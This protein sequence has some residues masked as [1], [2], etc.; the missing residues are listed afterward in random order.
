MS[1]RL[2][3]FAILLLVS[4]AVRGAQTILAIS[5]ERI[6]VTNALAQ[7]VTGD[8]VVV[9]AGQAV[10]T[11]GIDISQLGITLKGAGYYVY[12][13]SS[14]LSNQTG[15][16]TI[17]VDEIADRQD[18]I[19]SAGWANQDPTLQ[20]R[21]S[22]FQFHRGTN[23]TSDNNVGTIR[24]IGSLNTTGLSNSN[25]RI[26]HCYF[27]KLYGRPGIYAMAGVIDNCY[28]D[29]G[30]KAGIIFDGK[31]PNSTQ[32]GH[33]SWATDVPM[34]TV[35]EGVY[36]ENCYFT[37]TQARGCTDGF[38]GSRVVFRDNTVDNAS[39]ENHGTDS[40]NVNRGG[41]WLSVYR[42]VFGSIFSQEYAIH[43]RSGSGVI[44][45]NSVSGSYPGLWRGRNY[46]TIAQ[47]APF[48]AAN[49]TNVW[50]DNDPNIYA[51]GTHTG[52]NRVKGL[53]DTNANFSISALKGMSIINTEGLL[54][55]GYGTG[56]TTGNSGVGM[57]SANTATTITDSGGV[58][59]TVFAELWWTN[60]NTY[61]V[62]QI[63]HV[64][65]GV[66]MGRGDLLSG[67]N[68]TTVP[69]P[70]GW[71]H[72]S[73]DPIYFWGN[74][75]ITNLS[76]HS[77]GAIIP[78][79]NYTNAVRVD[80]VALTFPHPWAGGT[81]PP[82]AAPPAAPSGLH[83]ISAADTS[84]EIQWTDNST[85]EFG[86]RVE[87][88]AVGGGVG[89]SQIASPGIGDTDYTDSPLAPNTTYFYRV[90]AF[91]VGGNSGYSNEIAANT[92]D[93]PSPPPVFGAS[94]AGRSVTILPLILR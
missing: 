5:P 51:T 66:G 34:G 3:L 88:S 22:G 35:Y 48:R 11:R 27:N 59:G 43:H 75:G 47:Y 1:R 52:G 68:D 72:Q 41:R 78:G 37:N 9:P 28:F 74:T 8:T 81:N 85:N 93:N 84:L 87:R 29:Q 6:D 86:F 2:C 92:L 83:L 71:P 69:S 32:K 20:F 49:G 77:D 79:R 63:R 82:P 33:W 94:T 40:S 25:W 73:D 65:D 13:A 10:W 17:I 16:E 26:D 67:G 76:N 21:I 45:S 38:T 57:I 12:T 54:P 19:I 30:G 4:S 58:G 44:F 50:D 39:A 61:T 23:V 91:G 56:G 64:L 80:Y 89:Y 15:L 18:P 24:I 55:N 31:I 70:V 62:R 36:V 53:Q 14:V 46:R 60:G 7:A 90:R 42:N